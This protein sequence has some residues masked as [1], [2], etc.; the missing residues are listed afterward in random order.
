M[1]SHAL[2][3][4]VELLPSPSGA[5]MLCSA[6]YCTPEYSSG[7]KP[8]RWIHHAGEEPPAMYFA[9][10]GSGESR[11]QSRRLL[12]TPPSALLSLSSMET[13]TI[14]G[15]NPRRHLSIL[16]RAA[17]L[18]ALAGTARTPTHRA[19]SLERSKGTLP[20]SGMA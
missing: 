3:P 20:K 9:A 11:D 4:G 10:G 18:R 13:S 2:E 8:R 15:A 14:M 17:P 5:K 7:T 19:I 6:G 12:A 1:A 16:A